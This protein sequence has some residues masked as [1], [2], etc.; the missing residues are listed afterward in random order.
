[1]AARKGVRKVEKQNFNTGLRF[2][3]VLELLNKLVEHITD[4]NGDGECMFYILININK[5]TKDLICNLGIDLNELDEEFYNK[6]QN[7]FDLM[8]IW[9]EIQSHYSHNLYFKGNKFIIYDEEKVEL[10]GAADNV[11]EHLEL[12]A[13]QNDIGDFPDLENLY[14]VL[15]RIEDIHGI[16]EEE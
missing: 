9:S 12:F 8:P 3:K 4:S 2:N 5:K 10:F 15:K 1:M 7:Y 6:E 11:T 14:Q 16:R 13:D